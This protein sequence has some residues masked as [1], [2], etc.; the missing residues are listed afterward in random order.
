[1]FEIKDVE[2]GE[3]RTWTFQCTGGCDGGDECDDSSSSSE[4]NSKWFCLCGT[5]P[6]TTVCAGELWETNGNYEVK[7]FKN[8]CQN[9]CLEVTFA[10]VV[11]TV[12]TKVCMCPDGT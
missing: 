12:W 3:G 6:V 5:T 9:K 10:D 2:I 4:G 1:V 8:D 7:C 11:E